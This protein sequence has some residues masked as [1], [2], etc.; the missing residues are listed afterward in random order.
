M[1]GYRRKVKVRNNSGNDRRMWLEKGEHVDIPAKSEKVIE[2]G[3]EII[4]TSI[5]EYNKLMD[6]RGKGPD[7]HLIYNAYIFSIEEHINEAEAPKKVIKR[8]VKR[9]EK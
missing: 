2:I 8:K 7:G 5:M 9:L 6:E 1:L 4:I 3:E